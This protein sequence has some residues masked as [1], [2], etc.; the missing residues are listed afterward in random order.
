MQVLEKQV[1]EIIRCM[2]CGNC[3]E[4]CPVFL[5][6]QDESMVARGKIRL[7]KAFLQGELDLSD[8]FQDKIFR[9]LNCNA[10]VVTCPCGIEVDEIILAARSE[11]RRAGKSL[12]EAQQRVRDN[13]VKNLN[14]FGEARGERGAWLP[15][16]LRSAKPSPNLFH[17]G[18]AISYAS[19]RTGKAI[20]RMLQ[21]INYDFTMLGDAERC[22]GDPYIRIGEDE[23]AENI[24]EE[25]LADYK[26]LGVQRIITPCAGC[27]KFFKKHY[28]KQLAVMHITELLR[29]LLEGGQITPSKDL[30]RRII[31]FDGC[32]IGRHSG[33]YEP[34]RAILQ[35]LPGV[36]VLEFPSN[37]QNSQ[38]CGGPF[39]AGYPN[40]AKK[41][42]SERIR[43]AKALGA[44]MIAVA[45]PTCLIN[46]KE[47]AAL[48]GETMDVQDVTTLLFRS[49]GK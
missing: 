46:L 22:C 3:R 38:C 45:C 10:C 18:C 13:I 24:I 1:E 5:E 35:S 7:I 32:D 29:E 39:M 36:E 16:E 28:G 27:L 49:V 47:G 9:C 33:V 42:A 12:P 19:A 37:R 17:A 8:R 30:K 2:K 43:E 25:N 26:R 6:T 15:P 48:I 31:Y 14:P 40:L 41:I 20:I 21:S 34:P 4:V 44:D 11:M 23:L